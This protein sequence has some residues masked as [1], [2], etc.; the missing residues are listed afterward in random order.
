MKTVPPWFGVVFPFFFATTWI[1][2]VF[3]IS[4][5]GWNGLAKH[6]RANAKPSGS[7][8]RVVSASINGCNYNNCLTAIVATNGLWLQPWLPFR[9]FHPALLIPWSAFSPFKEQKIL[10]ARRYFSTV[11]TPDGRRIPWMLIPKALEMEVREQLEKAP[12]Q[13]TNET[14]TGPWS[15]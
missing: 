9:L 13:L 1:T 5:I 7:T 12:S 3:V 10:W 15:G 11:T 4:R 2:V 6:F 8:Y 14:R